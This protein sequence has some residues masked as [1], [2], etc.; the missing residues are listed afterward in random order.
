VRWSTRWDGPTHAFDSGT[1]VAVSPGGSKVFVTGQADQGIGWGD[2]ATV[3]YDAATGAQL[4]GVRY[5]D[6]YDNQD[7]PLAIA[8]SPGGSKVFV[9][10]LSYQGQARADDYAT[11]AYD[12]STGA[13]L[14]ASRYNGLV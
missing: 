9:T 2:F 6:P 3:A 10:G 14:W 11:V 13:Q 7:E 1:A 8:V 4:W 12:A 5:N